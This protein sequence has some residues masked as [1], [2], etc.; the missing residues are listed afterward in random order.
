MST[1]SLSGRLV[2]T[3]KRI[4]PRFSVSVMNSLM[5]AMTRDDVPPSP[6]PSVPPNAR[7]PSSMITMTCPMALMTLKIFSRLPSVAPTHLERKFFSLIVGEPAF[8]GERLG[9][10]RLAGAHRPREE[11]AHRHAARSGL[12]GCCRRSTRGLS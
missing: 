4:R 12:R 6:S 5:R 8:L 1:S 7:S 3:R 11:D 10:E 9:H 2:I